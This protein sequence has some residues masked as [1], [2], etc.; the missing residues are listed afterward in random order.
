VLA[1]NPVALLI[2]VAE[3]LD[4]R[5]VETFVGT[6]MLHAESLGHLGQP[7]EQDDGA[8]VSHLL[9]LLA[10]LDVDVRWRVLFVM[11]DGKTVTRWRTLAA[12]SLH[13][14]TDLLDT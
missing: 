6:D 4:I 12:K 9:H 14:G 8:V 3:G 5:L 1:D 2:N 13:L 7:L 10:I 11:L